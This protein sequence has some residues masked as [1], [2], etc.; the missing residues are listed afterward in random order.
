[1]SNHDICAVFGVELGN[2]FFA[3]YVLLV[4]NFHGA[5]G[6]THGAV[7]SAAKGIGNYFFAFFFGGVFYENTFH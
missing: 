4:V 7:A 1:M 6:T 5:T 2:F 3:V